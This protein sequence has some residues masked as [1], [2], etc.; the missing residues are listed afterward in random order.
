M[1][2]AEIRP[3]LDDA[4]AAEPW[5]RSLGLHDPAAAHAVFVRLADLGVTLD[6]LA[7]LGN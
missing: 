5:L 3:L 6:L 7:V 1:T 2:E 4:A